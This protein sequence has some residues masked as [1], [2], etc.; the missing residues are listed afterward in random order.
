MKL[1]KYETTILYQLYQL[2]SDIVN[3]WDYNHPLTETILM[4]YL[5]EFG[6]KCKDDSQISEDFYMW[7]IEPYEE[8]QW[9]NEH[10]QKIVDDWE[11]GNYN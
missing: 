3:A 1:T 2:A 11:L 7:Y 9:S 4:N 10:L 5:I 8:E 6:K